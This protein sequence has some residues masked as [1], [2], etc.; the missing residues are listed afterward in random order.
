MQ[1]AVD[2]RARRRAHFRPEVRSELARLSKCMSRSVRPLC[3]MARSP[4][5][6]F[7]RHSPRAAGERPRLLRKCVPTLHDMTRAP[8]LHARCHV[9]PWCPL[10]DMVRA[11][12]VHQYDLL[13]F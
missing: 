7:V 3:S 5:V 8:F 6:L 12:F 1:R 4:F 9:H 13:D 10:C 11:P 2:V